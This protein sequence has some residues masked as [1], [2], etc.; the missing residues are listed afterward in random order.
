MCT[1]LEHF[2]IRMLCKVVPR[3]SGT[4]PISDSYYCEK[5]GG[6]KK[7]GVPK[8]LTLPAGRAQRHAT[9]L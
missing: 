9:S 4:C 8:S 5:L 1:L 3:Y 6:A 2:T 7:L